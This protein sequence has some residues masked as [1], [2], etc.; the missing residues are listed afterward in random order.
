MR[1]VAARVR[2]EAAI[3]VGAFA[4]RCRISRTEWKFLFSGGDVR[5]A[6]RGVEP[7][8]VGRESFPQIEP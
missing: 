1:G 4:G 8:V 2:R 6:E 3:S 5:F 7:A